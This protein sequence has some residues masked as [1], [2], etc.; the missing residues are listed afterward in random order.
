MLFAAL[1]RGHGERLTLLWT[2]RRGDPERRQALSLASGEDEHLV[3]QAR[4]PASSSRFYARF[5][6]A[7]GT[8]IGRES[9]PEGPSVAGEAFTIERRSGSP[10]PP[11]WWRD[12]VVYTIF[13]DRFRPPRGGARWGADPGPD[14]PAGGHLEG[15]RIS[16]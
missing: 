3:F 2:E 4:L 7:D 6:L 16:G 14:R 11:A 15:V 8:I 5:E 10:D 1:R 9:D 13:V 12:A